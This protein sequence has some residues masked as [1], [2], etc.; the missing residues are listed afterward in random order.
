MNRK[1]LL[2]LAGAVALTACA[3]NAARKDSVSEIPLAP[4]SPSADAQP[5]QAP[6]PA[7]PPAA[8]DA[9]ADAAC[10]FARVHFDFD[11]AIL[12]GDAREALSVAAKC[13]GDKKLVAVTVEGHCDDRG[14]EAYNLA[15]GRRRADAVRAYLKQ[16]GVGAHLNVVSFGKAYPVASGEDEGAWRENRRAEFRT[17]GEKLSD[18]ASVAP[19]T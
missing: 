16:L 1:T 12:R 17:P 13:I 14:T 4:T 6:P 8:A 9:R 3:S 18:G 5:T 10:G 19:R 2:V 7:E 11:S 15:L